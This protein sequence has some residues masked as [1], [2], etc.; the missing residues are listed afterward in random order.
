MAAAGGQLP[1]EL[2]SNAEMSLEEKSVRWKFLSV[3]RN[4]DD[5]SRVLTLYSFDAL[6]ALFYD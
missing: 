1:P 5:V 3:D 2:A 4:D 6:M